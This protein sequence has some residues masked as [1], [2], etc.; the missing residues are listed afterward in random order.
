MLKWTTIATMALGSAS[1][2]SSKPPVAAKPAA[3]AARGDSGEDEDRYT[4]AHFHISNFIGQGGPVK[5]ILKYMSDG[6]G[7]FGASTNG[8]NLDHLRRPSAPRRALRVERK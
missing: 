4:D 5:E 7:S 3:V 6:C 2:C 1:A 8:S